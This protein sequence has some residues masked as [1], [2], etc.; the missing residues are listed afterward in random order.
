M[1]NKFSLLIAAF[2]ANSFWSE[3]ALAENTL[4]TSQ[5]DFVPFQNGSSEIA[6]PA[7]DQLDALAMLLNSPLMKDV[8]IR[9]VGH[10]D[11]SGKSSVNLRISKLR[12]DSVAA[13]LSTRL[14]QPGRILEISGV[15]SGEPL[16]EYPAYAREQ[17]RVAFHVRKCLH[18]D[19][20]SN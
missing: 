11:S 7:R 15:G 20:I 5:A 2:I 13:Y 3:L 4:F 9:I 1:A 16:P 12:A 14:D 6:R 8:C 10:S 18:T 19:L 17:R